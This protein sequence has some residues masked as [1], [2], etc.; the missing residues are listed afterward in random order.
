MKLLWTKT[1][2][3]LLSLVDLFVVWETFGYICIFTAMVCPI[4]VVF[5]KWLI[6][7]E[8]A[9]QVFRNVTSNVEIRW[10]CILYVKIY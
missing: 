8:T 9:Y 5:W 7:G 2:L 1:Q 10:K 6:T 3:G 4:A